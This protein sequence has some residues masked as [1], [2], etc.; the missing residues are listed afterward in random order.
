M[1]EREDGQEK[2]KKKTIINNQ[3]DQTYKNGPIRNEAEQI[4][5]KRQKRI[6]TIK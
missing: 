3:K 6:A 4:R 5:C 1:Q 2:V